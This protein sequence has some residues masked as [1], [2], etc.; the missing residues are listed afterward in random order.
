MNYYYSSK[1]ANDENVINLI[2]LN[3]YNFPNVYKFIALNHFFLS[4]VYSGMH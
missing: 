1:S 2:K 3:R 4:Q